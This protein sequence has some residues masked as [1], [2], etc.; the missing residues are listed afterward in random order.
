MKKWLKISWTYSV[1][2]ILGISLTFAFAPYEVFPLAVIV[3]A[4]LFYLW[5][6]ATPAQAL[7]LGFIFGIG[8]FGAGAYWVYIS[9]HVFGDVPAFFA[10]VITAGL[11]FI[12]AAYPALSGYFLNRYFPNNTTTKICYAFPAAWV[13]SE[14]AR[15]LLFSGFP[16]LILGYSQTNSPLKGFA[17]IFSVYGVS[18]AALI[19]SSLLL[20][21]VLCFKRKEYRALYT[22]LFITAII[23]IS[24]SL[25]TH[26]SW[27]Q[28]NGD[29][30]PVSLVQ[31]G[32][33]Q[34]IKWV[35][36]Y[37]Q[38]SFDRYQSLTEPLW[39]KSKLIIWP[40]GAIP[41]LLQDA[42]SYLVDMDARAK[43]THS[44][45]ILGIPIQ[46]SENESY[47]N[48]VITLGE[49]IQVY[50][51]R[52][53]V[54]FGEYVPFSNFVSPILNFMNLPTFAAIP[55]SPSQ[56]PLTLD[57]LKILPSICYEIAFPELMRTTDQTIGLLVTITNDAW[58]G[59]SA[60]QAQHLQMAMMRAIEL[61]R[62]VLLVSNDGITAIIGPDGKVEAQAPPYQYF[63]LNGT[64]QPTMG[65]TPWM[66]NGMSPL[67]VLLFIFLFM[68]KR[69]DKKVKAL[70]ERLACDA[71]HTPLTKANNEAP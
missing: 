5:L 47:Y 16:W 58:F 52:H 28:K 49:Q 69:A 51:K 1:A 2:L 60:A 61:S 53:L 56:A 3:P 46:S 33:P 45:L 34:S 35:P 30:I 14:W 8:F 32:I 65:L 71:A 19:T 54:P 11:I 57:N 38:L 18:L 36:E 7:R 25:L 26:I 21:A 48:A 17:P 24:G 37:L 40:E 59:K 42:K 4:V 63:V 20:N 55:G 62:P 27:T 50:R 6:S 67:L 64:V 23:W 31:G 13:I 39:G 68:T 10:F 66:R 44:H 12:M 15:S 41:T 43:A 22:S 70:Q 29:P 9:V